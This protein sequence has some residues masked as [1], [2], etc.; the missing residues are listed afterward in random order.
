MTEEER[1]ELERI[2]VQNELMRAQIEREFYETLLTYKK[3]RWYE[4]ILLVGVLAAGGGI[5]RFF[6]T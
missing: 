3:V 2:R 6:L 1:I 5:V 4:A